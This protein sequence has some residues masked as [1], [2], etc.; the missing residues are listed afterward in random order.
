MKLKNQKKGSVLNLLSG[1][2]G[3][4]LFGLV[5]VILITVIYLFFAIGHDYVVLP[6][7]DISQQPGFSNT[8][9]FQT[10][11]E[12][13]VTSYQGMDINDLVD[14]TWMFGFFIQLVISLFLAYRSRSANYFS[15]I[16]MLT[17]GL[18]LVLFVVG[19]FGTLI[20]WWYE[21]ILLKLFTN[22]A[23]NPVLYAYYV[24]N[25][26]FVFMLQAAL[27]LLTNVINLD[28]STLFNRKKREDQALDDELI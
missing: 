1:Y 11:Y 15:W 25:F 24:R 23:V 17:Y 22:L 14:D 21:E 4:A 9:E 7:Y 28:L 27:M 26:S 8:S 20:S 16:S 10:A 3:I 5:S 13:Q 6:M 18:M 19:L 12:Y 2:F